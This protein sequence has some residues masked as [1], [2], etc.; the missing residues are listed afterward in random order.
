MARRAALFIVRSR[1]GYAHFDATIGGQ[2][3]R[4]ALEGPDG[5]AIRYPAQRPSREET[6][7]A[8]EAAQKRYAQIA[9]GRTLVP[10][11]RVL[12]SLRLDEL[13]AVWLD[14]I[15]TPKNVDSV[16]VKM[17]YVRHWV[18]F[19]GDASVLSDGRKR[20]EGDKRTP[21]ERLVADAG[22]EDYGVMRLGH[23]LRKTVRKEITSLFEFLNWA[24]RHKHL[25]S[26]PPRRALPKGESGVRTGKQRAT[27]VHVDPSEASAIIA[28]L[29]EWSDAIR[30][31]RKGY[32]SRAFRVRDV[33]DF[34]WEMTW[35]PSTLAR[36]EIGRNWSR[37]QTTVVLEDADDKALYGREVSLTPRALAILER[38]APESGLIFGEHDYR[39]YLK[40]AAA[41]VLP[42]AKAKAFARYDF[43]HGRINNLLEA[44]G[45]M[46]G[47]AYQAGH[48]QLTTTNAYLKPQKRQGDA[49]VAAMIAGTIQSRNTVSDRADAV[50]DENLSDS[51][52]GREDSNLRP[53]DPQEHDSGQGCESVGVEIPSGGSDS[54][55]EPPSGDRVPAQFGHARP[56]A[57]VASGARSVRVEVDG[58]VVAETGIVEGESVAAV[59][60]RLQF[61]IGQRGGLR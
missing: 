6:R 60:A 23:A 19:T 35:R 46:L 48:K 26:V 7:A 18:A 9:G 24:Q 47:V 57:K 53:L 20:W 43:R 52:S 11:E 59:E 8:F 17:T 5:R 25:A 2:R 14:A 61:A 42:P 12:T 55:D 34:M 16:K 28:L 1:G 4:E 27:P 32:D 30:S 37:G 36:L 13:A 22:P 44:T 45:N 33:F 56:L 54:G 41:K 51:Q 3:Y 29:P 49:V 40:T 21:L 38:I 31:K 15:E 10:T 50:T 39:K 58:K